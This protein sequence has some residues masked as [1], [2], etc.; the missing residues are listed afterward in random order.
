MDVDLDGNVDSVDGR[1]CMNDT[2]ARSAYLGS[3]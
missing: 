3:T 1:M 2:S